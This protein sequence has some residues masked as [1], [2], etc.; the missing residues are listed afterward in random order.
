M[1]IGLSKQK[2]LTTKIKAK[3]YFTIGVKT[4]H[5]MYK[6]ND[7]VFERKMEFIS[8]MKERHVCGFCRSINLIRKLSGICIY[9][10]YLIELLSTFHHYVYKTYDSA[11]VRLSFQAA[12]T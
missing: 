10:L 7:L 8:S 5:S 6:T 9:G 12:F 4:E 11:L 2:S 1:G 3:N